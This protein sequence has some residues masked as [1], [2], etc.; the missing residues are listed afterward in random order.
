ME[1]DERKFAEL[2]LYAAKRLAVDP[3]GGAV[4]L[5]K[6]LFFAEFAHMRRHGRP[7]S[8]AEYQK[9]QFGPEPRRLV[10]VRQRLLERGS[11]RMVDEMYQGLMQG[12]PSTP[13]SLTSRCSA[14]R[15]SAL[16]T[17]WLAS[18]TGRQRP[19][20]ASCLTKRLA[21][22]WSTNGR[23]S[24]MRPLSY[25]APCQPTRF[26]STRRSWSNSTAPE[27]LTGAAAGS[28]FRGLRRAG[29]GS[30][31][32]R[33]SSDGRPSF[34]LF[35]A[36]P[37]RAVEELFT[38]KF[39]D[40]P[41]AIGGSGIRIAMTHGVPSFPAMVIYACL[42]TDGHVELLDVVVDGDYLGLVGDDPID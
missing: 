41:E 1:Y 39:D 38:R 15:S 17:A 14:L 6:V 27:S 35:E 4:K 33:G 2:L 21:G 12:R 11:A 9:L 29:E 31:P 10:P 13:A 34:E 37:L 30:L 40:Q 18:C 26:A 22:R 8:G 24:P 32:S 20:R 5:S 3:A 42:G 28:S 7:I 23:P 19:T 36:G 16:S 25:G